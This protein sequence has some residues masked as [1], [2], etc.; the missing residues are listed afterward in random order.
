MVKNPPA[1]AGAAGS[2]VPIPE[3]GRSPAPPTPVFLPGESHGQRSLGGYSP[4]GLK[5]L[6]TTGATEHTHNTGKTIQCRGIQEY[7]AM[8]KVVKVCAMSLCSH[9]HPSHSH[10]LCSV[11]YPTSTR[12]L[13][14]SFWLESL[15]GRTNRRMREERRLRME[16]LFTRFPLCR[17]AAPSLTLDQRSCRSVCLQTLVLPPLASSDR[18]Q[19][20]PLPPAPQNLHCPS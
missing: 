12:L 11:L 10:L 19:Q 13:P 1:S 15:S 7:L 4:G 17:I 16:N 2:A 6:D 9:G 18:A 3:L 20:L 5:E 8:E 14:S